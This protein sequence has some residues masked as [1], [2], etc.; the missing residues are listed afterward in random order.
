MNNFAE[1]ILTEDQVL[2][3]PYAPPKYP[4]LIIISGPSGVGKDT[5]VRNLI[6][7]RE[8]FYFVVTATDRRPRDGEV[9]GVD[10][11]FVSTEQFEE[12][13]ANDELLEYA[14]VHNCYK[15]VP[16]SQI[17][18]AL[19]SDMDVIM[20]VDPQGAATLKKIIPD[21]TFIFLLAESEE[22]LTDR[23][24][25][26]NSETDS[27]FN[28]KVEVARQELTRISEFDYCVVNRNGQL[29]E[30]VDQILSIITAE[31]CRVGRKP[32]RL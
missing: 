4:V 19:Q 26:R 29:E 18:H 13:I 21:A 5:V 9:D 10:Y 32:I 15:G 22:E 30:T 3:N 11:F 12:M 28:L 14:V 2:Q 1:T 23:L 25:G 6:T 31:R 7:K 16:K 20:R 24:K 27:S 17:R 8:Y